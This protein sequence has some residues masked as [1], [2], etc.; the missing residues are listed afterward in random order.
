MITTANKTNSEIINE[1][2]TA[3]VTQGKRCMNVEGSCAYG[4]E[5]EGVHCAVGHLLPD[6]C[7][8]LMKYDGGVS[9]LLGEF[10][11]VG[12]NDAWLREHSDLIRYTQWAH[13]A[14]CQARRLEYIDDICIQFDI[15]KSQTMTDW[16]N[17]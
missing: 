1:V 4:N 10:A 14:E 7:E 9:S 11:N 3:L 17:I 6:D 2:F 12:P 8:Y 16:T 13:D 5:V 15:K